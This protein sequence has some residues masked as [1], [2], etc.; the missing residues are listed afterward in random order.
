MAHQRRHVG[1]H[2]ARGGNADDQV[3]LLGQPMQ[4]GRERTEHRRKKTGSRRGADFAQGIDQFA[5]QQVVDA[6][7]GETAHRGTGMVD[8]QFEH[9]QRAATEA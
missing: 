9:R 8:R 7:R 3:V 2:L 5:V 6:L 1:R 4:Q